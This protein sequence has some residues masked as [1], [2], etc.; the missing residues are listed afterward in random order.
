MTPWLRYLMCNP[1]FRGLNRQLP[2]L[3]RKFV[4]HQDK[5]LSIRSAV[6]LD[7]ISQQD[8]ERLP[9]ALS[10]PGLTISVHW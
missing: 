2:R 6:A 9:M 3:P 4:S 7:T 5:G 10:R 1:S 8:A